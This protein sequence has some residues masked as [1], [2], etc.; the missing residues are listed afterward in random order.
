MRVLIKSKTSF[1]TIEYDNVSSIS[2]AS[3]TYTIVH[4]GV[5]TSYSAD[6]Y[7]VSLLYQ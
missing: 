5:S 7:L 1:N 6:D 2:F 4:G 3:N